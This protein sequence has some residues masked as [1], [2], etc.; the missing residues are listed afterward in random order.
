MLV[1]LRGIG[2]LPWIVS[3][4]TALGASFATYELFTRLGMPLPAGLLPI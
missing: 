2:R 1:L 4:V 3:V